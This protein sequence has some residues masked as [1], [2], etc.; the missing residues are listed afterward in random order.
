MKPTIYRFILVIF[1]AAILA[2]IFGNSLNNGEDSGAK[3]SALTEK[4]AEIIVPDFSSM[5]QSSKDEAIQKIHAPLREIAHSAEFFALAFFVFL[6]VSSFKLNGEHIKL[7]I[8]FALT[9]AFCLF[10]A[11]TDETI[12]Y[13]VPGR[14]S[15]FFDIGMDCLGAICG[16]TF[17]AAA[18]RLINR[19]FNDTTTTA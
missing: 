2:F 3:S 10:I 8:S 16:M 14:A 12:Q 13:F 18:A 11:I 19:I 15:E 9:F 1:I 4:V 17:S 6:F 7:Y 5:S